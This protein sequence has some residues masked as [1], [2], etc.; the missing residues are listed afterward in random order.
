MSAFVVK[1]S[2]ITGSGH[3]IVSRHRTY[4]LALRALKR[5][6]STFFIE[7]AND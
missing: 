7:P 6:D 4:A 3:Y 1:A 2:K 5:G